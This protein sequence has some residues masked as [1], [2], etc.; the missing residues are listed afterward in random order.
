ML[1][2]SGR[3]GADIMLIQQRLHSI[4]TVWEL[5]LA[6]E[7]DSKRF[8]LIDGELFSFPRAR[9]RLPSMLIASLSA[10]LQ[11]HI[12]QRDIGGIVTLSTGYHPPNNLYTLLGPAIAFTSKARLPKPLE[13]RYISVMPDLAVE[14]AAPGETLGHLRRKA[15]TYLN[16]GTT[17]VWI[18]LPAEKGVDVCRS[19]DGARL[20]IEFVGQDGKLGGE[21]ILPGFELEMTRLFPPEARS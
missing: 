2:Q 3:Q 1:G 6:P 11:N 4:D 20:D 10:C 12:D 13:E 7:N 14:I 15:V 8:Y 18:V 19:V 17:M 16:T 9:Y 5:V 21:G